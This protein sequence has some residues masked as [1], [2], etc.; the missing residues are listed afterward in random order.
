ME[1]MEWNYITIL[2][3]DTYFKIKDW[4]YKDILW[5]L[6]KKWLNL[7]SFSLIPLN[8]EMNENLQF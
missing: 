4:I 6:V 3:L 2:L 8:F 1:G 5:V 7:I